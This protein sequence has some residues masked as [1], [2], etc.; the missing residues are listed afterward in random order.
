MVV[1]LVKGQNVQLT[2]PGEAGGLTKVSAGLHWDA[3]DPKGKPFDL[4]AVAF[5]LKNGK[6][7]K[8]ED[9]VFYNN[10][11]H[12]SGAVTHTGDERTGAAAGDD[13]TINVDLSV[14]P[15][16]IDEIVFGI[17]IFDYAAR[18]QNFGQVPNAGIHLYETANKNEIAK[19]DLGEDHSTGSAVIVA[20][21]Y[22]K[23]NAWKFKAIDS[24]VTGGLEAIA[25]K[26]GVPLA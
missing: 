11:K 19:Y 24:E 3:N 25:K 2:K 9:M 20:S 4:D 1:T 21:L 13:E 10:L 14:V 5:L 22:K 18:A 7:T 16:D 8:D 23:D 15:A 26:Y 12:S 17:T 6:I